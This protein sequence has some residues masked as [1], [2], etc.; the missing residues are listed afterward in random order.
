LDWGLGRYETTAAELNPVAAAVVERAAI[1]SRDRVLDV[2]CGTGNAALLAAL[3]GAQTTGVD[4]AARLLDVAR[5]RAAETGVNA[6]FVLGD[7]ASIPVA[8]ASA[9]VVL[10][11]FAVIFAPDPAAAAAE[12][13]RV[14]APGGRIL[15]TA[16]IPEGAIHD[17]VGIFQKAVTAALGLPAGP[18]AF[19]WH[20]PTALAGLF[21]PHGFAIAVEPG[22]VAFTATS[23]REYLERQGRDHPMS[24][25]GQALLESRG[26]GEKVAER[27][28]GVLDA[29]NEDPVAFRVTSRYVIAIATRA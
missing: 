2:G 22:Q 25:A 7:A 1:S 3:Q 21:G 8:A 28:L 18:P 26:E 11:V 6:T 14:T 17:C 12:L 24:V 16:W 29:A 20:E 23:A 5:A 13:A 10:S 19:A 15:L 9:D 4:P 27:A